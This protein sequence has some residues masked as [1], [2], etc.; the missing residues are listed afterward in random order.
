VWCFTSASAIIIDG[1]EILN[2]GS[3]ISGLY[4][5]EDP[6]RGSSGL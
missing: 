3:E 2:V 4:G 6:S 5:G 1:A